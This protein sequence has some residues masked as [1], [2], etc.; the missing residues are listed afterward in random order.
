MAFSPEHLE[1]DLFGFCLRCHPWQ[2]RPP[3]ALVCAPGDVE[4]PRGFFLHPSG[5]QVAGQAPSN[6]TPNPPWLRVPGL[7]YAVDPTGTGPQG[8]WVRQARGHQVLQENTQPALGRSLAVTRV[9]TTETPE[10]RGTCTPPFA[11][12]RSGS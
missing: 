11:A 5:W 10:G 2:R 12:A 9:V 1:A 4:Q 6:G 3:K 8:L 7:P